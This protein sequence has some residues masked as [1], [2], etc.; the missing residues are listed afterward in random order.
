MYTGPLVLK[1]R[2]HGTPQFERSTPRSACEVRGVASNSICRRPIL[3][4]KKAPEAKIFQKRGTRAK[5]LSVPGDSCT[6][7][8]PFCNAAPSRAPSPHSADARSLIREVLV[9]TGPVDLSERPRRTSRHSARHRRGSLRPHSPPALRA[10]QPPP[11]PRCVAPSSA[12]AL[13]W[14][15]PRS[16]P[17]F[18]SPRPAPLSLTTTARSP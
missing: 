3:R 2:S 8:P 18:L 6:Q 12:V 11:L 13:P 16:L 14:P 4:K 5:D 10:P 17:A 7:D 9:Y 15:A 1:A